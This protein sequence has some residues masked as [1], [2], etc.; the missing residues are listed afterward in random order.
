KLSKRSTA[1]RTSSRPFAEFNISML[2]KHFHTRHRFYHLFLAIDTVLS[3]PHSGSGITIMNGQCD[4]SS[5]QGKSG[6]GKEGN[7]IGCYVR[8][9]SSGRTQTRWSY[10]AEYTTQYSN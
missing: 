4:T 2:R 5:N 1:G 6:C 10:N 7:M 9:H 3:P 8:H